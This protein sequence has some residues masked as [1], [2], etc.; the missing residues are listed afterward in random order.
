MKFS[1]S[2]HLVT[3]INCFHFLNYLL[4]S[5]LSHLYPS[6]FLLFFM[7]YFSSLYLSFPYSLSPAIPL[8]PLSATLIFSSCSFPSPHILLYILLLLCFS[9]FLII[10]TFYYMSHP[11]LPTPVVF[12]PSTLSHSFYLSSQC[13]LLPSSS[14]S[15]F[16]LFALCLLLPLLHTLLILFYLHVVV[17]FF[18]IL[19]FFS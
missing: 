16:P 6:I 5:I 18:V 3:I 11:R 17:L 4:F 12:Y 13:L 2:L 7:P 15:H 19:L 14:V 1:L 8:L 10:F 9:T